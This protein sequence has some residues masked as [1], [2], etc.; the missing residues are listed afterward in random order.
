MNQH[1]RDKYSE[2]LLKSGVQTIHSQENRLI[3][4]KISRTQFS[5]QSTQQKQF[6]IKATDRSKFAAHLLD[7]SV[8]ITAIDWKLPWPEEM[9]S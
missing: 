1:L 9:S 6:Q 8:S 4:W 5:I 3:I 2:L 7:L